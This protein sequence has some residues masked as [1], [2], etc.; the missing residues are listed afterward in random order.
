MNLKLLL[1]AIVFLGL[2]PTAHAQVSFLQPPTYPG[3][4]NLF[5]ADFNGDGKPDLLSGAGTLAVGKGNGTFT[6]GASVS[7]TPLAVADF[8]GD[9]RADVLEQTTGTLVVLLGKGDGTFQSPINTASGANLS[10]VATADLNGDGKADV[11]GAF[12]N[13][14]LVYIGKGDGTFATGVSYSIGGTLTGTAGVSFGD[15]N[16]DHIVDIAV[17]ALI[18][19]PLELVFLGNGDGTFQ[20]A[21]TSALTYTANCAAVGDFNRDGKL[22]VVVSCSPVPSLSDDV[23]VLLGNGD[24]T[25]QAPIAAGPGNGAVASVDLNRD[26]NLD[27]VVQSVAEGP[28]YL[29]PFAQI[30]LGN[31]DGTFSNSSNYVLRMPSLSTP[32]SIGVAVA[33]FNSD[34]KPDFAAGNAVLLSKGNGAFQGIQLGLGNAGAAVIAN[35]DNSGAPGLAVYSGFGVSVYKNNGSGMLLLSQIYP[36]QIMGISG[37][38]RLILASDLNADGNLDLFVSDSDGRFWVSYCVLIGVGDGSF[39]TPV[40]YPQNLNGSPFSAIAAD[41][42]NDQLMDVALAPGANESLELLLGN[43][44]GSFAAPE[45]VF[46]GGGGYVVAADFNRD[47]KMDMAIGGTSSTGMLLGNGDGT[48][49]P[50]IFPSNLGNFTAEFT[51]DLNN[52][53]IPDLLSYKQVALGNGDGT[54]TP[55]PLLPSTIIET[56]ADLNNDGTPDLIVNLNFGQKWG[57]L[58]GKGDGTFGAPIST[59]IPNSGPALVADMNGDGRPDLLFR[60]AGGF[61]V[62][63]NTTQPDFELSSAAAS[64][65]ISAGQKAT[66]SLLVTAAG[67]F[68]GTVKLS[69]AMSPAVD[70]APTC[71]LSSSSVQVSGG[72]PQSSAVTVATTGQATM[73][74]VLLVP[75]P[76]SVM[77]AVSALLFMGCGLCWRERRLISLASPL[78]ALVLACSLSCAGSGNPSSI[79]IS[80]GTPS[81]TYTATVTATSGSLSHNIAFEVT[82]K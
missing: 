69:C 52:D 18:N 28:A 47:G 79:H 31:G 67:Q 30:Y 35:F 10:V 73:R 49:E 38:G 50:A 13:A 22:D 40:C 77:V 68:T 74:P 6:A 60:W 16:G 41:F 53:G 64:S 82:V 25:F 20:A 12:N 29:E 21:R 37:T 57:I 33:D 24:G 55:L 72:K 5:V 78:M 17:T 34:G 45:G 61:G 26:G 58:M 56:V 11:V 9:G 65:T 71:S 2:S 54:F 75:A 3:S 1:S 46:D 39:Q 4:G 27:L 23:Y 7:G 43:G 66:F 51:A 32:F 70:S 59:T 42:R 48:F 80:H 14:L 76:P 62:M 44:N 63:L 15:F 36:V 81:G 19:S 8:N